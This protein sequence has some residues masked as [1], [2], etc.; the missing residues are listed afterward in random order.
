MP[1]TIQ[2]LGQRRIVQWAIAYVLGAWVLLQVAESLASI[3]SLSGDLLR[4]LVVLLILGFIVTLVLAW[5]HAEKG[6]Q[7]LSMLELALL[8]AIAIITVSFV[9]TVEFNIGRCGSSESGSS[10]A[11]VQFETGA[12]EEQPGLS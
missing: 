6:H 5:F 2:K 3:F 12:S 9:T 1:S 11:S 4:V 8:T 7:S 10:R